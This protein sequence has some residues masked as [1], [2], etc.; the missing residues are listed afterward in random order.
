[1]VS[2]ESSP[3]SEKEKQI[4]DNCDPNSVSS[5]VKDRVLEMGRKGTQV[6]P[7][8]SEETSWKK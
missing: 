3:S 4:R 6:I 2:S 8:L 7:G 1:M 5:A